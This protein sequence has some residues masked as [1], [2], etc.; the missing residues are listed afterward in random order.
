[1]K[2]DV[3]T[4]PLNAEEELVIATDN[5]GAIGMHEQDEV[6]VPYD[7]VAYYNFRVAWMECVAAGAEPFSVVIHN[8][9]GDEAWEQLLAGIHRG[10]KELAIPNLEI[11]GST[12][13]N[14]QLLQSAIGMAI[15][16]KRHKKKR[17]TSLRKYDP[18]KMEAAVI[19]KPL[20]GNE[21]IK[22]PQSV[23]PLSLFKW[24]ARQHGVISLLPVGSKGILYELGQL[25]SRQALE[26]SVDLPMTKTS[27]PA[28][29]FIA[30]YEKAVATKVQEKSGSLFHPVKIKRAVD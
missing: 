6:H 25:F 21:V 14:F 29:C 27:G 22:N 11:T 16:G 8:F 2:R 3:A 1:M 24:L 10:V 9:S 5:S 19:G 26:F 28:T 4:I 15:I 20:V 13:T 12:E 23:A 18:E 17:Q 30:V 7:V